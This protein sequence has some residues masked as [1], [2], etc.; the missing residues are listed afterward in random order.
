MGQQEVIQYL[1]KQEEPVCS[2][3]IAE[4]LDYS[5]PRIAQTLKQLIKS[6]EILFIEVDHISARKKYGLKRRCREYYVKK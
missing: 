3:K 6:K 5:S 1:E 2:R 4:D